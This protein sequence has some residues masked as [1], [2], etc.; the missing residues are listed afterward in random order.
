MY[1]QEKLGIPKTTL[2]KRNNITVHELNKRLD[3][4][5]KEMF[6]PIPHA[7]KIVFYEEHKDYPPFTL[8]TK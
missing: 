3:E 5:H 6:E 4:I 7:R 8:W 2:A 1:W